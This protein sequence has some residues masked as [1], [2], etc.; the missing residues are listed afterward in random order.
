MRSL[1]NVLP[2]FFLVSPGL[3]T[4]ALAQAGAQVWQECDIAVM[5]PSA[6]EILP[7]VAWQSVPFTLGK[8]VA[9]ICALARSGVLL[10]T[11]GETALTAGCTL[12]GYAARILG[13]LQPGVA[14]G[15]LQGGPTSDTYIITKAG[16]WAAAL[17]GFH[18]GC[19]LCSLVFRVN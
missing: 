11:G 8:L 15:E 14:L 17:F 12:Q 10:L 5:Q 18:S 19:H 9:K 7:S 13:D 4:A 1:K 3:A 16:G 6:K 2:P